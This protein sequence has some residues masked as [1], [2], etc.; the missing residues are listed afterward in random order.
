MDLMFLFFEPKN[1]GDLNNIISRQW[2][3]NPPKKLRKQSIDRFIS[4]NIFSMKYNLR[5]NLFLV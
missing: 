4:N 1:I 2:V 5:Y 3:T